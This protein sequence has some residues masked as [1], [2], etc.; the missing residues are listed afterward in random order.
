MKT[1][2]SQNIV[3][4]DSIRNGEICKFDGMYPKYSNGSCKLQQILSAPKNNIDF[5]FMKTG[6]YNAAYTKQYWMSY[7]VPMYT[8][9]KNIRSCARRQ[10]AVLHLKRYK[11]SMKRACTVRRLVKPR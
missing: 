11:A 4:L 10:M 3:K 5:I 2:N 6:H 9:I 7:E 8:I 1:A